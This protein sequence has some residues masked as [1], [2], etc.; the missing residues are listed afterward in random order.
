M[1]KDKTITCKQ[2]GTELKAKAVACPNCGVAVKKKKP[3]YQRAWFIALCVVV[4]IAIASSAGSSDTPADPGVSGSQQ[5]SVST[6]VSQP[7]VEYIVCT[8]DKMIDELDGNALKAENTYNDAFVEVTGRLEVIDSDGDYIAIG[9]VKESWSFNNITCYIKN[10][11]QLQQ[12]MDMS[13]DDKVT[14]RGQIKS[15]GEILGYDLNIIE[16]VE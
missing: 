5:G 15:V 1:S 13:I 2:C 4:V 6:P 14:V 16:I 3:F 12:V 9:P 11:T 8:A 7:E 10:D